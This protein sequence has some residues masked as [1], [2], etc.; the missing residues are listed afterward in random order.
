[1]ETKKV[2]S[3]DIIE[4]IRKLPDSDKHIF[5]EDY[6]WYIT[7]EWLVGGFAGRSFWSKSINESS[8]QLIDYLYRHI[9]HDS[10]V[11]RIV[12]SSG[13]PDL[14]KVYKYCTINKNEE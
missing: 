6:E 10:M 12:S 7:T 5:Y 3:E 2:T 4:L 14:E 11:G 9:N 1:M 8:E 13:F